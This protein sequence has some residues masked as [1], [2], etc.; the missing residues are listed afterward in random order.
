MIGFSFL[1]DQTEEHG[2]QDGVDSTH[3]ACHPAG[4]IYW[5]LWFADLHCHINGRNHT[6]VPSRM[7]KEEK[8]I[9]LLN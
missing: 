9:N 2:E 6:A 3:I 1:M 7:G 5:S 4:C 8:T